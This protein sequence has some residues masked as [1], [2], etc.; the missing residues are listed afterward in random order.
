MGLRGPGAR[1][2]KAPVDHG[3]MPW[4]RPRLSRAGRIIAF[5]ESLPVTKGILAGQNMKLLPN[6]KAFIKAVY[7]KTP[8][9]IAIKS[10]PRGNGKTGLLAGLCLAHLIGPEAEQRGEVYS[11]AIDKKQAG[12]I[13]NEMK[14]I[15]EAVPAFDEV[16]NIRRFDKIIEVMHGQGVGSIY[17]SLSADVRR[18]H[19]LS[20][21]FW[22]YDEY[23]QTR[24]DEL[25]ANLQTAMGKR[26]RSLGV[27]I[28]TQA[29]TDHHPLSVM[30][31]D[32]LR[33]EDPD[34]YVQLTA[35][36]VDADPFDEKVWRKCNPAWGRFLDKEEFRSQARRA[37]RVPSFTGRF[38]NLRLNQRVEAE[39]RFINA[40]DWRACG[41]KIDA[42]AL[43]GKRCFLGLDLSSTTDLTALAAFFPDTGDLLVWFWRPADTLDEAER[44]DHVPYRVW[45][46]EGFMET[47]PGRAI[48][49][50][51][52]VHRLGEIA[53]L[54]DVQAC[55][56]DRW[57]IEE[58]KRLIAD[59]D[60]KI[61]LTEWG[62]GYK[63]MSPALS[64]LEKLIL[65]G[66]L[67]HP[68]SP[69]LDYC[70]G[71]AIAVSD[72]AGGR[73][74]DKSKSTGR[75][76]GLQAAAM[77]VGLAARTPTKKPS[78]YATRG[79]LTIGVD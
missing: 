62:Q 53:A 13:F 50:S 1:T 51:Y 32:A 28:S 72:P 7:G 58:V 15:I 69:P 43:R 49:K 25:M 29:A 39:D 74:L 78:I 38:L 33:G 63:D 19:G 18:A 55:A 57:G 48:D 56:Y 71:N 20:P 8:R 67:R 34:V 46:R 59:D 44:L 75:I 66:E 77:A 68:Q 14:A 45:I 70:V 23:A 12:L 65:Q 27:V 47:T 42:D 40:T 35:A 3:E 73:K 9:R 52:V 10:E 41:H 22:V 16:C 26:K 61:T 17:E 30:I 37:Q 54:Y 76:D 60:I 79:A 4:Q 11:A 31:D 36:P 6:Q 24:T 64:A 2:R 5:M 21:T